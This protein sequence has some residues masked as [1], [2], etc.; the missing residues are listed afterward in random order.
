MFIYPFEY[1]VRAQILGIEL[2]EDGIFS[3][4]QL[5]LPS[6]WNG[7]IVTGLLTMSLSS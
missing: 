4:T 3:K 1:T 7:Y 6:N 5:K 2:A